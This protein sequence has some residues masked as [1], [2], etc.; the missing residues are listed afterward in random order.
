MT[1]QVLIIASFWPYR[2]GSK[3]TIGLAKYLPEFDWQPIILTPPLQ[4]KPVTPFRMIE[5]P[6]RNALGLWGRLFGLNPDIDAR[7]QLK[8]RLGI[9]SKNSLLEPLLRFGGA[10]I[11]Y[12]DAYKGWESFAIKAGDELISSEHVDAILSIWPVT[13]H[14]IARNLKDRYK[15]PWVADFPDLWS[16]NA[17]YIYGPLRRLLD[18]RLELKTM[19]N[20]D[21]LVATSQSQADKLGRLHKGKPVYSITHGF[22][23]GAL[24]IPPSKLTT[25]FTITYTGIIYIGKRDPSKL[26]IALKDLISAGQIDPDEIEVRFYGPQEEWLAKEIEEY[27]LAD[28]V[29]QYG[30]I[31][32]DTAVEKQRESQLLLQLDWDDP[33][34]KGVYTGKIFEYLGAQRPILNTG[35]V[36]GN[37]I[38][39][40]LDETK[41][42][43]HAPTVEDIEKALK[44]LYQEYKTKGEITYRGKESEVNKHSQRNMA[45]KFAEVLNQ[46]T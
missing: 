25:K 8:G 27:G 29:K 10:I 33:Q 46:F 32:H 43:I 1:K 3:R 34:E 5:T 35:G 22:D 36:A 39:V 17:Y 4:S 6:Y 11:N 24:N 38:D 31:P 45:K 23:P 15:I 21:A 28:I 42:G 41:A 19:R 2:E 37:V 44:E 20:A 40:L 7:T 13:G 16:Q 18:R 30:T 14:L 26:L 12:P 9:T